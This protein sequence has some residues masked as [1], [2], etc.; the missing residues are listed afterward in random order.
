MVHETRRNAIDYA[1]MATKDFGSLLDR[2]IEEHGLSDKDT[3]RSGDTAHPDGT[4]PSGPPGAAAAARLKAMAP[5]AT[6]DLHGMTARDAEREL[7]RFLSASASRGLEK[8][9]VIHGKGHHSQGVQVLGDLVRRVLE[10]SPVAG[11]FGH[12]G[13]DAGGSGATWVILR[14]RDYFSR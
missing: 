4:S 9:L 8:V 3:D 11:R 1:Y 2:W 14:R 7:A 12:P 6:L 13:R 10:A 5:Q